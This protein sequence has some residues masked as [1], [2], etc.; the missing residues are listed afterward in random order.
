M[1]AVLAR[2]TYR[3]GWRF[4]LYEAPN[5]AAVFRFGT[6]EPDSEKA[7][8]PPIEVVFTAAKEPDEYRHWDRRAACLA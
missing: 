4:E 7:G 2:F 6:F 1:Q 5:G 3:P 8:G